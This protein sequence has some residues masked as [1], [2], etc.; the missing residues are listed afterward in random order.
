MIRLVI[1]GIELIWDTTDVL[2]ALLVTTRIIIKQRLG[3]P[4]WESTEG[5]KIGRR[6]NDGLGR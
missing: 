6:M 4:L 3:V 5:K 2:T 1:S